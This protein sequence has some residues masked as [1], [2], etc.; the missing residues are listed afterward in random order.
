MGKKRYTFINNISYVEESTT[1]IEAIDISLN[2]ASYLG[3]LYIKSAVG[4]WEEVVH[5]P[6]GSVLR[7]G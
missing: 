2:T 1:L 7:Y 5:V 6:E 4:R 3:F